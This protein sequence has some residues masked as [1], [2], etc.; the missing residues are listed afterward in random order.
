MQSRNFGG[1]FKGW[2]RFRLKPVSV[3]GFEVSNV[4]KASS[5]EETLFQ[6]IHSHNLF[7]TV[8]WMPSLVF[9]VLVSLFVVWLDTC[10]QEV[11]I[12]SPLQSMTV[13]A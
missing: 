12:Q 6:L 4:L 13:H 10:P 5:S 8:E 7:N 9:F 2:R 3:I 1:V 11:V